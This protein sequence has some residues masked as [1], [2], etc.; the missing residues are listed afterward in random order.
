MIGAKDPLDRALVVQYAKL[1]TNKLDEEKVSADD[2]WKKINMMAMSSKVHS[3]LS[4]NLN[5]PKPKVALQ[6]Y[7]DNW[8]K[9]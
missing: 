8:D 6:G 2:M 4:R 9:K 7:W 1:Q 5:I 3:D